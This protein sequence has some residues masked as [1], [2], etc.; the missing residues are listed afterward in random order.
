LKFQIYQFKMK[1]FKMG[2]IHPKE[3]KL[4]AGLKIK[5]AE[6]PNQVMIPLGHYLG[7]PSNAIVAKGDMVR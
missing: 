7:A 5:N 1:T 3:Y 6:I 2:G 4:S